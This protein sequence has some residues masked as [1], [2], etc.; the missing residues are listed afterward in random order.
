MNTTR[1]LHKEKEK[2]APWWVVGGW[3]SGEGQGWVTYVVDD[4]SH[5]PWL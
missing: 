3:E 2:K 5:R 1:I 4:L